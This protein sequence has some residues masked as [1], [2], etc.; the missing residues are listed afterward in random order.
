MN[1]SISGHYDAC[2]KRRDSTEETNSSTEKQSSIKSFFTST[3]AD[4]ADP[5]TTNLEDIDQDP[6]LVL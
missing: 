2:R 3:A 4:S 6:D 1:L 5:E